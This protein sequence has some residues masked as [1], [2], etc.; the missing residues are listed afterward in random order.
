MRILMT[1]PLGMRYVPWTERPK[2]VTLVPF[3]T[4]KNMCVRVAIQKSQS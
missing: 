3:K 4:M 2:V 1:S